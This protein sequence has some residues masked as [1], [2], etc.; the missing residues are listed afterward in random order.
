MDIHISPY[1]DTFLN[2]YVVF[3][4]NNIFSTVP[5]QFLGRDAV[6]LAQGISVPG[7]SEAGV[8][9]NVCATTSHTTLWQV[10]FV[11]LW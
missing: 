10:R 9:W 4:V 7:R 1:I 5:Q 2:F 6:R 8:A 3:L 11:G